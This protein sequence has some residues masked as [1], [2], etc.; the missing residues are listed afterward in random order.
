[1]NSKSTYLPIEVAEQ[2]E[3]FII[4]VDNYMHDAVKARTRDYNALSIIKLLYPLRGP[5]LS[6]SVLYIESKIKMKR[7]FLNYLNLCLSYNF[8]TKERVAANMMYSLTD[9]G[10]TILDLFLHKRN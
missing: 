7:S 9:K 1:M 5:P 6:F 4:S 3:D 10:R 8:V 2:L